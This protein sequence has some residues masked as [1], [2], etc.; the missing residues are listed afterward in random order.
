MYCHRKSN[1]K[2]EFTFGWLLDVGFVSSVDGGASWNS[3]TQLAGPMSLS[4][5]PNT[6]QGRMVADYIST[7]FAGGTAHPVFAVA[8]TPSG[9]TFDQV[10]YSP[11]SGLAILAGNFVVTSSGDHPIPDAASDHAAS[12]APLNHH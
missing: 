6:S 8:K 2:P 3:N 10:M 12:R 9:T 5:V 4:W 11:A 1:L 7:S